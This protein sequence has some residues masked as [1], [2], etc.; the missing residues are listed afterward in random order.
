MKQS[1]GFK[2]YDDNPPKWL[3]IDSSRLDECLKYMYDN[4]IK[5]IKIGCLFYKEKDISFGS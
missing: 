3:H 2:T 1:N 4:N 5:H